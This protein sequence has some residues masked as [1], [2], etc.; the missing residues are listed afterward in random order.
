MKKTFLLPSVIAIISFGV[1]ADDNP[2]SG[3][4]YNTK[5]MSS[6][7]YRCNVSGSTTIDC[8]FVQTRVMPAFDYKKLDDELNKAR[9]IFKTE[10]GFKKKDC[11][12]LKHFVGVLDRREEPKDGER[13][14]LMSPEE[15]HDKLV[16]WNSG[17]E[18]CNNPTEENFLKIS[19]L[20]YDRLA[21]T[22][23]ASP[24]TFKQSYHLMPETG[25]WI[26][27][28]KPVGDCG[29]VDLSRFEPEKIPGSDYTVWK[30][31]TKKAI[32][33]PK[34][35]IFLGQSCGGLDQTEY[36]YD[37]RGKT[38]PQRCNYIEFSVF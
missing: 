35:T 20:H 19:R 26:A 11:D 22:C 9:E 1:F 18:F 3:I 37:W 4:A 10:G 14:D 7:I 28:S 33:N 38:W 24:Y 12:E 29:L 8:D 23:R 15:R 34:G 27:D 5:E 31:I 16:S 25:A 21:K 32:S 6:I 30:F 2:G 13:F 17:L 36:V